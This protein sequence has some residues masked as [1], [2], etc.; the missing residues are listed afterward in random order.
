MKFL[1]RGKLFKNIELFCHDPVIQHSIYPMM[2]LLFIYERVR[3]FRKL[4]PGTLGFP[5]SLM[6]THLDKKT[7]QKIWRKFQKKN[8]AFARSTF[9]Y[10]MLN[11]SLPNFEF[12]LISLC[13][14]GN[15][16]FCLDRKLISLSISNLYFRLS[17][18]RRSIFLGQK[19]SKTVLCTWFVLQS[20]SLY[21]S[22]YL[23][24]ENR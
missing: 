13:C 18:Q 10:S 21:I 7:T 6:A 1:V 24:S 11:F 4:L 20:C 17:C 5:A 22:R 3:V 9:S 8:V 16:L 2:S 19:A 12:V 14:S 23:T 15:F